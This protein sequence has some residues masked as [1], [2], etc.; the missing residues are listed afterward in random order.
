MEWEMPEFSEISLACEINGY[1]N[2]E[3]S[4]STSREQGEKQAISEQS[5]T[6]PARHD[7]FPGEGTKP[8]QGL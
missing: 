3:L 7:R 8:G 4:A 2:A 6:Q 1:A 5:H